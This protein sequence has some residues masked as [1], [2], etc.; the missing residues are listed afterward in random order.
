MRG[1]PG[2]RFVSVSAAAPLFGSPAAERLRHS[3]LTHDLVDRALALLPR[4]V[5]EI[6]ERVD[7]LRT[8]IE[9]LV[10]AVPQ[11]EL[12]AEVIPRELHEFHPVEGSGTGG[13]P[14]VLE[15]A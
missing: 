10:L 9:L 12:G 1:V 6:V 5:V 13:G 3:H 2:Q 7:E 4:A 14:V 8:C 11:R 15:G